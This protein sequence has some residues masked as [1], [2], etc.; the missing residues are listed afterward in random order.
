MYRAAV[1]FHNFSRYP[2]T[3]PHRWRAFWVQ[4]GYDVFSVVLVLV[5]LPQ[6]ALTVVLYPFAW[7]HEKLSD[8][9]RPFGAVSS[10]VE[11]WWKRHVE[12]LN[13]I[14]L[15]AKRAADGRVERY[16]HHEDAPP[17]GVGT[18][19]HLRQGVRITRT[20]SGLLNRGAEDGRA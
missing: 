6:L 17:E 16:L 19:P 10:R 5:Y 15:A 18:M 7:L 3:R 14:Y 1:T 9:W 4:L 13:P 20:P 2:E 11:N 12:D 8:E